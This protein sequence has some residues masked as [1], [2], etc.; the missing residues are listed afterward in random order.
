MTSTCTGCKREQT[1]KTETARIPAAWK[2]QGE[3][4]YCGECWRQSHVL[5]AVAIPA[6][7]PLD[8]DW[9]EFG[10]ALREQWA[11]VTQASNW[12]MTEMYVRDDRARGD[13]RLKPMPKMYL[14]PETRR[15][16]PALPAQTCAALEQAIRAKYRAKRY[17]VVWTCKSSLP[18][19][20]YPTPLPV[21]N[22]GWTVALEDGHAIVS[23]RIGDRRLRVRLRSGH[24]FRRQMAAVRQIVAGEAERG[25][26]DFYRQGDAVMCKMV[27]W[28][29]RA[30]RDTAADGTLVVR[31]DADALLVAFNA[32]DEKLWTYHGDQAR[33]WAQ[34]HAKRNQR[35][36]DDSKAEHRPTPP[37]AAQ[38]AAA[39]AKYRNRMA[40]L[41]HQ[42]SMMIAGYARRRH[43]KAVQ[44]EDGDHTFLPEFPWFELRAKIADKLDAA[45]I[46]FI[47]KGA[48]A[49]A[50]EETAAPLARP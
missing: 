21:P 38:R 31:T 22:Q 49:E 16:F 42:A 17:E 36:A 27:A 33:R 20:R 23:A 40:S 50:A 4:L 28:L 8:C 37:F 12:M 9:D 30:A 6:A 43:F 18:T 1:L 32:K 45:G 48:S 7:S 3:A 39:A 14:Y 26:L 13:G 46:E 25:Q 24:Q 29:P 10:R 15:L 34:E 41:T 44:Y 19:F 5:R 35:L 11:L 47:H 2:R